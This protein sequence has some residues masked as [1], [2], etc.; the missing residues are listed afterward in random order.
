LGRRDAVPDNSPPCGNTF[1]LLCNGPQN[2]AAMLMYTQDY[3][4]TL[5]PANRWMDALVIYTKNE[6][7]LRCL[8]VK[9]KGREKGYG[10]TF[11]SD[12]DT[13]ATTKIA[14]P[15]TTGMLFDSDINGRNSTVKGF[16]SLM[17]ARHG[18]TNN[19]AYA[20]GH[21]EVITLD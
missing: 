17:P 12:L 7:A 14:T 1:S 3:D 10:Y 2:G 20:D 16:I 9:S 4:Q 8:S 15:Q 5:P 13:F 19:V 6:K 18:K 11:N 21:A